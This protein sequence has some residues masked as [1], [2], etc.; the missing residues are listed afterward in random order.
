MSKAA[1]NEP[2]TS[3]PRRWQCLLR[4]RRNLP[5][6]GGI[7]STAV[8]TA[9]VS[10]RDSSSAAA[11]RRDPMSRAGSQPVRRRIGATTSRRRRS[12]AAATLRPWGSRAGKTSGGSPARAQWTAARLPLPRR[13]EGADGGAN[14]PV[15]ALGR[16]LHLSPRDLSHPFLFLCL[17]N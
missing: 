14:K 13:R 9:L 5:G 11:G 8:E 12:R 16:R 2:A 6:S 1:G 10:S 17:S 15:A 7:F 4:R 3:R